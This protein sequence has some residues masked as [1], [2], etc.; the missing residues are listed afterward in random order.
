M[1]SSRSL[2]SVIEN[3]KTKKG[4]IPRICWRLVENKEVSFMLEHGLHALLL[5]LL[6]LTLLFDQILTFSTWTSI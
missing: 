6:V 3:S 5:F 1:H 2:L 4:R